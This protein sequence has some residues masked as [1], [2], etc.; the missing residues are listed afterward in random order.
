M[1]TIKTFSIA[2]LLLCALALSACGGGGSEEPPDDS[3]DP[4]PGPGPGSG[5]GD[6][7]VLTYSIGGSVTGMTGSG[8]RISNNATDELTL[9][10]SGNFVFADELEGGE[11]YDVQIVT[12][13]ANP[14]NVCTLANGSGT[15]NAADVTGVQ[16]ECTGP[17]ALI[18]T[19]PADDDQNVSRAIEPILTFSEDIDSA[20]VLPE[21]I[22]L[23]SNAGDA[24]LSFDVSGSEVTLSPESILLPL[25]EYTL[26]V[27]TDVQ[28]SDG[29]RL[30][31]P[32][33]R[34]FKTRDAS[35]KADNPIDDAAGTANEAQITFD[36]DGN[37]LAVWY[38]ASAS[39][40]D[41]WSN[42]YTAGVGWGTAG[43]VEHNDV[44]LYAGGARAGF[45]ADGNAL[46]VWT[47]TDG[48][49]GGSVWSSRFVPG[50][51]WDTPVLVETNP[52]DVAGFVEFA[53]HESG[54]AV[55][56][57]RQFDGTGTSADI[58]ANRHTAGNGWGSAE[59]IDD[60][61]EIVQNPRV[62][63]N[64]DG[65]VLAVWEQ[66]RGTPIDIW[67]KHY[68]AANGWDDTPS[69]IS[70]GGQ[71]LNPR[72][73]IDADG[74]ALVVYDQEN[75]FDRSI[76]ANRY[77]LAGGWETPTRI[78][79]GQGGHEPQVAFDADG[80]ALAI[81]KQ[82][83]NSGGM[84]VI[85][86]YASRY[87]PGGDWESPQPIS[88][89]DVFYPKIAFDAS[90]HA[91]AVWYELDLSLPSATGYSVWGNRYTAGTGWTSSEQI[92]SNGGLI[93]TFMPNLA[94]DANGDAFA[95]WTRSAEVRVN[96]FE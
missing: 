6:D 7:P 48:A 88:N 14:D 44:D 51:G 82:P 47:Q 69:L 53:M 38:Q 23:V 80:N 81:W 64:P 29:G 40:T 32:V 11:D 50:S 96:R 85:N 49:T 62:A 31:D 52:G 86:A 75:G 91:L 2:Q 19:A 28:G 16:I 18:D 79:P 58:W 93:G 27:T 66:R 20:T 65:K 78:E 90:G 84:V 13:P 57:W 63:I 59:I 43:L 56:V 73:A 67:G 12:Q 71:A 8:L 72:P 70:L 1:N 4:G 22:T 41:L 5:S 17:L 35:W 39:G 60:V 46:A 54:D 94:I 74:N 24:A 3:G 30:L 37:A 95:I 33:T 76:Y 42:Y 45:D 15:V 55:A 68:T 77:T 92:G 34:T 36:N 25:T 83:V 21:N 89:G 61:D 10:A 87:T 26:T 9:D